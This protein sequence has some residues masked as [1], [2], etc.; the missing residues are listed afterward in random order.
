MILTARHYR[1]GNS[2]PILLNLRVYSLARREIHWLE[3][4]TE[5]YFS[6][7]EFV[8]LILQLTVKFFLFFLISRPRDTRFATNYLL[9][10]ITFAEKT[11]SRE[12]PKMVD[13]LAR[14]WERFFSNKNLMF[15]LFFRWILACDA[16]AERKV[17]WTDIIHLYFSFGTRRFILLPNYS[18]DHP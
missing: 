16:R 17:Q 3:R 14:K 2:N 9:N 18:S 13:V 11:F 10:F 5:V 12:I 8:T 15:A 6:P 7:G 4:V 1:P